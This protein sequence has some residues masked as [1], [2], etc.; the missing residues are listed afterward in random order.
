M[1]LGFQGGVPLARYLY[2]EVQLSKL[3]MFVVPHH[4]EDF[5]WQLYGVREAQGA[6]AASGLAMPEMSTPA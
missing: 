4:T 3:H 5:M 1:L 2:L 6:R